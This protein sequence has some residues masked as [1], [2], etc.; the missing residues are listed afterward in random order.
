VMIR[1]EPPSSTKRMEDVPHGIHFAAFLL[2]DGDPHSE[3]V[4]IAV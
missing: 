3:S 1:S 2:G 4:F